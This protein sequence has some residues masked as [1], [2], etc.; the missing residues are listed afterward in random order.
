MK[1]N[2]KECVGCFM[3]MS[4]FSGDQKCP[5]EAIN[6]VDGKPHINSDICVDCGLCRDLCALGAIQDD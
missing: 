6:D 2:K 3:C 1:V 5:V 4:G